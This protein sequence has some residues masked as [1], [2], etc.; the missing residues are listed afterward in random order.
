MNNSLMGRSTSTEKCC[1]LVASVWHA[2]IFFSCHA[3]LLHFY[4]IVWFEFSMTWHDFVIFSYILYGEWCYCM[5]S[6]GIVYFFGFNTSL[7][8]DNVSCLLIGLTFV[9]PVSFLCFKSSILMDPFLA[10]SVE[11]IICLLWL[12]WQNPTYSCEMFPYQCKKT[13]QIPILIENKSVC[14]ILPV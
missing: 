13:L 2:R 12:S 1:K 4:D 3:Y 6:H 14:W 8:P 9:D 5:V 11:A 7:H 10:F